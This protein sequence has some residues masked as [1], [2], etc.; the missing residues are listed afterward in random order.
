MTDRGSRIALL[1]IIL[2]FLVVLPLIALMNMSVKPV[3]G[4][5]R[6]DSVAVILSIRGELYDYEPYFTPGMV[7]GNR[8][9][10]LVDIVSFLDDVARD[11][12]V[13]VTI[14]KLYPTTA[15]VAKCEEIE[16][17]VKRLRGTGKRVY[18]F[19]P[20]ITGS[21]YR[22]ASASDSIFMPSSGYLIIP[23]Y[24]TS[25]MFMRGTLD[26]LGVKPNFDR[27]GKYKSAPETYTEKRYTS[28]SRRMVRWLLEDLYVRFIN[29]VAEN[30][31]VESGDVERWVDRAIF[32]PQTA[33]ENGLI[34]RIKHWDQ[35]VDDLKAKGL[36]VIGA[37][38]YS[39]NYSK[40]R[41]GGSGRVA[42]IHAQG[43]ITMGRSGFDFSSGLRMGSESI[44]EELKRAR[45]DRRIKAVVLRV[46]S[47]G[48]DAIA[49]D[50]I[51]REVAITSRVKPVVVSMSDVAAS[52]GYE[53][54]F[55]ADK[56][57]ANPS[58]LTGSIGSFMGK[59]NM[60]G[61]YNKLGFTK[62]EIGY[63]EKSLIFSD[64]RDFS[65]EEWKVI[66]EE[67]WNFYRH[68]IEEI[69][70]YRG[71]SVSRVDSLGRGRV[72]TGGQALENGLID[73]LGGLKEA[74]NLACKLSGIDSSR[75]TVVHYPTR[76]SILRRL[77]S[78]NLIDDMICYKLYRVI[79]GSGRYMTFMR[80][81]DERL[82]RRDGVLI[83]GRN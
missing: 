13:R 61:L 49:S 18:T 8:P 20:I 11:K 58:T 22:I 6:G 10:S 64:Y 41:I 4:G 14:L 39:Q 44:V 60:R 36:K 72:W 30:R 50:L 42:V 70:R 15:G 73:E 1:V 56:I 57:V 81:A 37:S 62:D 63:G 35:I 69:A 65:E 24:A 55:R 12:R 9:S 67:H 32:S 34:D 29:S 68:W 66:R 71:M 16:S 76:I 82:W 25:T 2:L 80:L 7:F 74:V 53:I 19:S 40:R 28:E 23:G 51:S 54:S 79:K 59:F 31:G 33:L 5:F 3:T 46:D 43:L 78:G 17:A 45:E 52:G 75:V 83:P 26:K 38:R 21:E 27:I 47:P 48:G 77:L